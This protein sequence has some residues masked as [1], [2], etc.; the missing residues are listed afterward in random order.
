MG[1]AYRKLPPASLLWD[2]YDYK[3]LTGELIRKRKTE[4]TAGTMNSR[5]YLHTQIGDHKYVVHRVVWK[6]VTGSD[7]Y[8]LLLDHKDRNK[9]NNAWNNLRTATESQNH[10]NTPKATGVRQVQLKSAR[11]KF[12]VRMK[13]EGKRLSLGRFDTQEE[14]QACYR[15]AHVRLHGSFSPY[16]E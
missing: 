4:F 3:P 5:G 12:D 6:W 13:A 15:E 9:T 14:A 10:A 11:T 16:S 2:R 7:P 1:R 8:G